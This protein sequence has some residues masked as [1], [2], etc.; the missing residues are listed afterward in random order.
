MKDMKTKF[1]NCNK[2]DIPNFLAHIQEI[3][4]K[5]KPSARRHHIEPPDNIKAGRALAVLVRSFW[6]EV[7]LT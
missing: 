6:V 3:Y 2:E 4:A 5:K 1:E 7:A